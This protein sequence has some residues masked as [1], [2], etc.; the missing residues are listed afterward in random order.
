M[1]GGQYTTQEYAECLRQIELINRLT[2]GYGPTLTAIA[3]FARRYRAQQQIH[4]HLQ[5]QPSLQQEHRAQLHN[6]LFRL[7]QQGE[8]RTALA[9]RPEPLRIL[10]IGFGHGDSLRAIA[11]WARK[12]EVDVELTGIDINPLSEELARQWTPADMPI[13]YL[14]GDVFSHRPERPYDVVINALFMHHLDDEGMR[15][16][17]RWMHEH[18][19]L[20]FFINDL[21]RHPLPYAFIAVMTRLFRFNRLVQHDAPLSVARSLTRQEWKDCLTGA[22]LVASSARISWHWSFRYGVLYAKSG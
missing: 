4:S 11:R 19:R 13:R 18:S 16:A 12:S 3:H 20:G 15:R 10:D 14:T 9:A 5:E 22:G 17:I 21:H 7:S 6:K 2:N 1:D 8:G